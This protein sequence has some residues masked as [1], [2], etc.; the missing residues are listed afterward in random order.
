M[1]QHW[2]STRKRHEKTQC[3][4]RHPSY[5]HIPV[6]WPHGQTTHCHVHAAAVLSASI[7]AN[8]ACYSACSRL[9]NVQTSSSSVSCMQVKQACISQHASSVHAFTCHLTTLASSVRNVLDWQGKQRK[10]MQDRC[11]CLAVHILQHGRPLVVLH[12]TKVCGGVQ[13][14]VGGGEGGGGGSP[15][16]NG[17]LIGLGVDWVASDCFGAIRGGVGPFILS[18]FSAASAGRR[19]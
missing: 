14:M 15:R 12:V 1:R 19:R 2:S 4:C 3:C 8:L 7:V 5:K 11:T 16:G 17:A 13:K 10:L 18:C 6:C 9:S